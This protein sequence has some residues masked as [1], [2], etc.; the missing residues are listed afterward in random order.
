MNKCF[1]FLCMQI[2]QYFLHG[3]YFWVFLASPLLHGH[4][5][6]IIYFLLKMFKFCHT[7]LS[8]SRLGLVMCTVWITKCPRTIYLFFLYPKVCNVNFVIY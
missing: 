5:D 7:P 8:L 2:Y 1:S 3:W 4:K 6:M